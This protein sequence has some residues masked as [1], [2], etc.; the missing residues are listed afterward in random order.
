MPQQLK[1]KALSGVIWML[2]QKLGAQI[3]ALVVFIILARLLDARDFGLM[4]MAF[5]VTQFLTMFASQ[6]L[7]S[8]IIQRKELEQSHLDTAFWLNLSVGVGVAL[9]SVSSAPWI[10]TLYGETEVSAIIMVLSINIVLESLTS[11]QNSILQ[12]RMEFKSIAIRKLC[13]EVLGGA[14]GITLALNG[15]GVW[16]LVIRPIVSLLCQVVLFWLLT[17][18]RPRLLFS[19]S[20]FKDIV[21]YGSNV[22]GVNVLNFAAR[23][24]D[25]FLIGLFMGATVLGQYSIAKRLIMMLIDL[26]RGGIGSVAWTMFSRMQDKTEQLQRAMLQVNQMVC[27]ITFPLFTA[28]SLYSYHFIPLFFGEKWYASIPII[29]L[30]ALVGFFEATRSSHESLILATGKSGVR[31]LLAATI[32]V[33]NIGIFFAI[34]QEGIVLLSL[35]YGLV[36]LLLF[37]LWIWSAIGIIELPIG[38]YIQ[39]Y[40]EAAFATLA[41]VLT[42]FAINHFV[43]QPLFNPQLDFAL[44]IALMGLLYLA[45]ISLINPQLI[46]S[47][48]RKKNS[49]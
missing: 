31:L 41:V 3:S 16:S 11:V 14:V 8:A 17:A 32:A 37:P 25:S 30:L 49:A 4:A 22:L 48:I 27:L 21:G 28:I 5:V 20:H 44:E 43:A 1:R 46:M 45:V 10:A 38:R 15:F 13:G 18:W 36:A 6:G 24:L 35:G 2:A 40:K 19:V 42:H 12:R 23:Q 39:S 9:I 47:F 29:Q 33:A 34:Y 26:I 7:T